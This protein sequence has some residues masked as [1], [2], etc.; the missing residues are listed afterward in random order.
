MLWVSPIVSYGKK[1]TLGSK[2]CS[3][4][5][6]SSFRVSCRFVR[7]RIC[8][9]FSARLEKATYQQ[10]ISHL[11]AHAEIVVIELGDQRAK[12]AGPAISE[13]PD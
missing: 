4:K 2:R 5:S 1:M 12:S 13:T 6:W 8:E 9:Y 10:Y 11:I 3:E 7:G